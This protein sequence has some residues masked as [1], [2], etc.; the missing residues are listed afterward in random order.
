[1]HPL[2]GTLP[3]NPFVP[4]LLAC[5][6]DS[7]RL[8]AVLSAVLVTDLQTA[9]EGIP[10]DERAAR[11]YVAGVFRALTYVHEAEVVCR[12]CSLDAVMLD[13]K[14][15]PQ[16]TDFSLS[17]SVTTGRTH[18]LCG[19]PDYLAPEIVKMTGHGI[20][21]DYWALGVLMFE[22]LA[23][24]SPWDDPPREGGGEGGGEGGSEGGAK[25]ERRSEIQ[26]Y[27]AITAHGQD[28]APP[29]RFPAE[30]TDGARGMISE[31]MEPDLGERL[32]CR[33][34]GPDDLT[35]CTEWYVGFPWSALDQ[36]LQPDAKAEPK[37]CVFRPKCEA[38]A[39]G[40]FSPDGGAE[41]V[42]F[43]APA[44]Y[45][46]N[47]WCVDWDFMCTVGYTVADARENDKHSLTRKGSITHGSL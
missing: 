10:L 12:A 29:L 24:H 15:Y 35:D 4:I 31:L 17:K 44:Y 26:V 11:F 32:G 2:A 13:A 3:P 36:K 40:F 39:R 16:L 9:C 30:L 7:R 18:T 20:E 27:A 33:G 34:A 1:M 37:W 19:T 6:S 14:G 8:F 41:E 23:A 5:F 28:G 22:L 46:E 47:R 38:L 21:A 43:E 25:V 42:E 45:G